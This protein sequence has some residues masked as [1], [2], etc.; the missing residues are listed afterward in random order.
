M[1]TLTIIRGLPS[2]G[3]ST[4][5]KEIGKTTIEA[6]QFFE[7]DGVYKFD[8]GLLPQAHA[9][10]LE[11]VKHLLSLGHSA[12]VSN[13]FTQ[14]WEM[15][16]YLDLLDNGNNDIKLVVIDLFDNGHFDFELAERNKHGVPVAAIAAMRE[17]YE[18]QWWNGNPLPPWER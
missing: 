2:S 16:P 15:Q 7:T 10:C 18:T 3:K 5:A 9:W 12:T 13:T 6:D 4:L 17:R 1:Q 8:G 14:R 11:S